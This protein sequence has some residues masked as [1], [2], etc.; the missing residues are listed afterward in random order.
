MESYRAYQV[1]GQR[2]FSLVE[3]ELREPDHDHVRIRTLACGVCHSDVLAVEGQRPDPTR[4][5][6]PGHEIVGVIDAVGANVDRRWRIGDRVGLGFLGGQCNQCDSCRRGDFVNCENQ[7]QPGTTEDGGYAEIVYARPSGLVRIP[8]G[9]DALTAAPLLCAGITVFNALQASQAPPNTLVAVQGIGGLGHLGIQYAKKMGYRVAAIAR[10]TEKA[11][12]AATLGADHYVDSST[13]DPGSALT[14]L[15]GASAIVATAASGASM[16][17]LV[18]GL[19]PRGRLIVV[20]ASPEP[21]PV[22]TADLIFGGRSII[23]SLT[24]SPIENEDNLAFSMAHQI[25]PMIEPLPFEDAP[26]A[27]ERMMSG[28]A[29]FRVVLDFNL[30]R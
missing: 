27:Y 10:G 6:V 13:E 21:I 22:Q 19:R 2:E 11:S 28:R 15:G 12:L 7:P 14:A 4:P 26:K 16:A 1:T 30:S 20:G 18:A 24:G 3:R 29:R 25:A 23:G 17:G 5:V 9:F 8:E